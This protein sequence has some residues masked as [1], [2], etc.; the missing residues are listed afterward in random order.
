M[1]IIKYYFVVCILLCSFTIDSFAKEN[2]EISLYVN[3]LMNQFFAIANN[4]SLTKEKKISMARAALEKN[5]DFTW[6]CKFAL[7]RY[8]RDMSVQELTDFTEIYKNFLLST[9]STTITSYNG[10]KIDIKTVH[11]LSNDEY[12]VK[13]EIKGDNSQGIN[14]DYLVRQYTDKENKVTYKVFDIVTE[15]VS[16]ISSQQAEFTQTI[17]SN[18]VQ[19]LKNVLL[20]KIKQHNNDA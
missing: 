14:M 13:V 11:P 2:E 5:M 7:G 8:R 17:G 9:Y 12:V 6:M 1:R 16:L 15:G 3:D 4:K 10:E 20:D 19:Y 18:S